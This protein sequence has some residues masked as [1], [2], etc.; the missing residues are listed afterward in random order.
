MKIVIN[1][2]NIN[3]KSNLIGTTGEL[4]DGTVCKT[5]AQINDGARKILI[6]AGQSN[7]AISLSISPNM[8]AC[9][10]G[11]CNA[12]DEALVPGTE[13][14]GGAAVAAAH[15]VGDVGELGAVYSNCGHEPSSSRPFGG[16]SFASSSHSILK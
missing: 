9:C 4:R 3:D 8:V 12:E 14:D 5:A 10:D 13:G 11:N 7:S 2:I 6:T 16:V 15:G 1:A